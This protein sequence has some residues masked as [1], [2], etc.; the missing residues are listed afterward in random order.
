MVAVPSA[1]P[2]LP[3]V[4]GSLASSARL[5]TLVL[6]RVPASI[7]FTSHPTVCV[8][9]G[10]SRSHL[11]FT[12][13]GLSVAFRPL[14]RPSLPGYPPPP[15]RF[16]HLHS[17]GYLRSTVLWPPQFSSAWTP[18]TQQG[19]WHAVGTRNVFA[20]LML[21]TKLIIF[22]TPN[23]WHTRTHPHTLNKA[24]LSWVLSLNEWHPPSSLPYFLSLPPPPSCCFL[25]HIQSFKVC[26]LCE[27]PTLHP[28]FHCLGPRL[29]SLRLDC[30]HISQVALQPSSPVFSDSSF[31]ILLL[32]QPAQSPH[33]NVP[34]S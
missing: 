27:V 6:L 24:S 29:L 26:L 31:F 19:P 10:H 1:P 20:V 13:S 7:H 5:E 33:L 30:G 8:F 21:I 22:P 3:A 4:P 14:S 11:Q 15:P 12:D 16:L 23:S 32:D 28:K 34:S 18:S 17:P 25:L 9:Q 2:R